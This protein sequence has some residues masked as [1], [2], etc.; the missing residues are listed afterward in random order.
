MASPA[1]MEELFAVEIRCC[2]LQ[3]RDLRGFLVSAASGNIYICGR[4]PGVRATLCS[5]QPHSFDG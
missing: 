1:S 2:S 4:G 5:G 3:V